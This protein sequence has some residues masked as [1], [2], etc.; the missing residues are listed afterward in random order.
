MNT[1]K[2]CYYFTLPNLFGDREHIAYEKLSLCEQA[3]KWCKAKDKSPIGAMIAP[4][5][6]IDGDGYDVTVAVNYDDEQFVYEF[7]AEYDIDGV[8]SIGDSYIQIYECEE[9]GEQTDRFDDV[10]VPAWFIFVLDDL[11]AIQQEKIRT[12]EH[13]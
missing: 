13:D 1:Q 11:T 5:Y 10:V 6:F 4:Q 7:Q 12:E 2:R 3:H 8:A 9:D